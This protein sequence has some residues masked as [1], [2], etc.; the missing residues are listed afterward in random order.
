MADQKNRH[1]K[2]GSSVLDSNPFVARAIAAMNPNAP[3]A[4]PEL[5]RKIAVVV[6]HLHACVDE[7]QLKE[8]E[9]YAAL[10]FLTAS[11]NSGD[12]MFL[13]DMMGVSMRV[14]DITFAVPD[15]TAPNVVGPV[16]REDA[17]FLTNP[18]SL[19]NDD[20]P[21]DHVLISG[22]VTTAGTDTPISGAILDLWQT[23]AEGKYENEDPNQP[24]YNFR[25]RIRTD[26]EGHYQV[27]TIIPGAYQVG[28]RDTPAV[29]FM[30]KLGRGRY[31]APHVHLLVNADDHDD[32]ITMIYFEGQEKNPVDCIFSCRP[33]NM[34]RIIEGGSR[35]L[36]NGKPV[37]SVRFDISLGRRTQP[38]KREIP[39]L[40]VL[41]KG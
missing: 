26:A 33:Q 22:R 25:G 13:A 17:P 31:R 9:L 8:H 29:D 21:G 14:N 4:D 38:G 11:C 30:I 36:A 27:H 34:A 6:R 39:A 32:L 28:N 18:G 15:G 24:D 37:K 5:Q 19:V 3:G 7:L 40:A 35:T 23:N 41:S 10:S 16:Y 2:G 20:E 1:E 12:A